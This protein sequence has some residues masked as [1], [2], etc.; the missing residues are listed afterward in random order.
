ML[1]IVIPVYNEEENINSVIEE[2]LEN[3]D[4]QSPYEIIFVDDSSDDN[5]FLNIKALKN[6]QGLPQENV[7]R[8]FMDIDLF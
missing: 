3:I 6:K 8:I 4:T 5:T 7:G 1:S 2:L